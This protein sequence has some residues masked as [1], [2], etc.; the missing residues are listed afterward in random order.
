MVTSLIFAM[1]CLSLVVVTGYAGQVSLAQLT[2]AGVAGF[3][4]GTLTTE[5]GRPVPDRADPRGA[6]RDGRRGGRRAA[7]DPGARTLLVAVVTLAMAYAIEAVWFR[8]SDYVPAEGKDIAGPTLLRARSPRSGRHRLSAA[9]RSACSCSSS[10]VHR[11]VRCCQAAHEPARL[12][13]CSRYARTSGPPP[14]RG[15]TSCASKIVAFAIGAFIAGL[16]GA[17]LGYKQG[18]VTFDSFDVLVGLGVFATVVPRRHHVGVRRDPRRAARRQRHRLLR[19]VAVAEPGRLVRRRSPAS[20]LVLT[21]VLNPEGIVGPAPRRTIDADADSGGPV[22][23]RQPD[24]AASPPPVAAAPAARLADPEPPARVARRARRVRRRDRGRDRQLRRAPRA[25]S[26]GSSA[27]TARARR[28]C[29]TR[30]AGS[31][32]RAGSVK[33]GGASSAACPRTGGSAPASAGRSKQIE[34]YD[35]LTVARTSSPAS[36]AANGD[37]RP[38]TICTH[39]RRCSSSTDLAERPAGELSQGRRQLVS[40][41]RGLSGTRGWCCSTNRPAGSTR[42]RAN[43]SANGCARSA[44][45]ASRSCSSTTTCTWC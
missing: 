27:R 30:S 39:A 44:T 1:I 9:R 8:N 12:A 21:V 7:G 45:A 2:L 11:R 37:A 17:M 10:L 14:A 33:L 16:G 3:L 15:S 26:S 36:R 38:T 29:S 5:L 25:R 24:A 34:L 23:R 22:G 13:R 40:I 42:P 41:A 35:D 6:R 32:R 28:P 43:G 20:A 31:P 18:N 4:L 19:I